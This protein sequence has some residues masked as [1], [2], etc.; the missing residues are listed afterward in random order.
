MQCFK[1]VTVYY[2]C[3][4]H[5]KHTDIVNTSYTILIW[6]IVLKRCWKNSN[7]Q[8]HV[9]SYGKPYHFFNEWC[10]DLFIQGQIVKM[11]KWLIGMN[12]HFPCRYIHN[13]LCF[14]VS[15]WCGRDFS[16]KKNFCGWNLLLAYQ[17]T[18]LLLQHIW[19]SIQNA[20][21]VSVSG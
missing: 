4:F 20:S 18:C 19:H 13:N 9:S 16:L 7:L 3:W 12:I 14:H 21:W 2:R 6:G 17:S 1:N 11:L 5:S 15:Y 8:Y 10:S